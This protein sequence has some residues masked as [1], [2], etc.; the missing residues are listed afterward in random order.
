MSSFFGGF[1]KKKTKTKK[2]IE[3]FKGF[4]TRETERLRTAEHHLYPISL[5]KM[6]GIKLLVQLLNNSTVSSEEKANASMALGHIAKGSTKLQEIVGASGLPALAKLLRSSKASERNP[7]TY[8]LAHLANRNP[9][10]QAALLKL[11]VLPFLVRQ[12]EGATDGEFGSA[13]YALA[14]MAEG[15]EKHQTAI[16]LEGAIAPLVQHLRSEQ[17][18]DRVDAAF[19]LARLAEDHAENQ[20][21]I[22]EEFEEQDGVEMVMFLLQSGTLAERIN[23][24]GL[25]ERANVSGLRQTDLRQHR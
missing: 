4:C 9:R 5:A 6:N 1:P 8:A 24:T 25:S 22:L 16:R 3:G 20:E 15:I 21:A 18:G 14:T 12:L 2:I 23:A 19:C 17:E 10:H 7:A 11:G 13:A